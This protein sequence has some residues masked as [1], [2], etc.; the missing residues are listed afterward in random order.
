M[1]HRGWLCMLLDLCGTGV[2]TAT[3]EDQV[4]TTQIGF[5]GATKKIL[6]RRE[7]VIINGMEYNQKTITKT[8]NKHNIWWLWHKQ[9]ADRCCG[10]FGFR[11]LGFKHAH[12]WT[13][14]LLQAATEHLFLLWGQS[15][16][17]GCPYLSTS[18]FS[19][20]STLCPPPPAPLTVVPC[21]CFVHMWFVLFCW[22]RSLWTSDF[23]GQKQRGRGKQLMEVASLLFDPHMAPIRRS[24]D[25]TVCCVVAAQVALIASFSSSVLWVYCLIYLLV[26]PHRFSMWFSN[27]MVSKSV[28]SSLALWAGDETTHQSSC[29]PAWCWWYNAAG[30]S[31]CQWICCSKESTWNN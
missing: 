27:T 4:S 2:N 18:T 10:V 19:V 5:T 30:P 25:G 21:V 13:A 26:T 28:T 20:H 12:Q 3:P 24:V 17:F 8:M 11:K 29:C 16:V 7:N 6:I 1:W 22:K 23:F 15:F 31:R 9:I 14:K